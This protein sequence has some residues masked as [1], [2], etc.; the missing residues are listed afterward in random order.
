MIMKKNRENLSK[1]VRKEKKKKGISENGSL[2]FI[3]EVRP[4]LCING[5]SN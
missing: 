2:S 4:S 3:K 5:P 1:N